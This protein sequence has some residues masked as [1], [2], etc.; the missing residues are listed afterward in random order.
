VLVLSL[1]FSVAVVHNRVFTAAKNDLFQHARPYH[2]YLNQRY[3]YIAR[4]LADEQRNLVVAEY[5]QPYP[6]TI[7]FNDIMHDSDHW[8]N[9]CYADYF[10]L[11][12]IKIQQGNAG[13]NRR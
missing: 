12:K 6:R 13:G 2:D 4:A 1:L 3:Q 9:V 7:Y 8:R 5:H 11:E 10:G